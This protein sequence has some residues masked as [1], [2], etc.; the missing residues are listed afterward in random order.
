MYL[1]RNKSQS[2]SVFEIRIIKK[3]GKRNAWYPYAHAGIETVGL[4]SL[5]MLSDERSARYCQ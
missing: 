4:C 3:L 1:L 2:V 5:S